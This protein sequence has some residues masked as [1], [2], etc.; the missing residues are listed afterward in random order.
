MNSNSVGCSPH[1]AHLKFNT[2][3]THNMSRSRK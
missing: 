3:F 1:N 2:S